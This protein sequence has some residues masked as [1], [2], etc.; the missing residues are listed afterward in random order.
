MGTPPW[1][2]LLRCPRCAG[3]CHDAPPVC[4]DCGFAYPSHGGIAV[5]H[6][7]PHALTDEWAFRVHDFVASNEKLRLRAIADAATGDRLASTRTRLLALADGLARHRNLLTAILLDAGIDAAERRGPPPEGVLGEASIT[8]YIHQIHRDWG[9]DDDGS[10]ENRAAAVAVAAVLGPSPALGRMLVLGAGACRLAA[11]VHAMGGATLT[12]A[13]DVNPLP[14]LVARRVLAGERVA[15]MELPVAPQRSDA[16][17]IER[18]LHGEHRLGSSFV[19]VFADAFALPFAPGSFDT[20]LTP[21]FID[22]VPHDIADLVPVVRGMLVDGGR[23]I[24]HGPLIYNPVHTQL[25]ARYCSDELLDLVTSAGFAVEAQRHDRLA[26][27]QSPAC[28]RGRAEMVFSF[29][30]RRVAR[31]QPQPGPQAPA[32]DQDDHLPV[33]AWDGLQ[34]YAAPHPLFAAVARLVDGQRSIADIAALM[35]RDYGLPPAAASGGVR[36]A[37][38]EIMRATADA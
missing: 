14:M 37:L 4:D 16:V 38:R 9:W 20:V 25:P 22:Q 1:V 8:S 30:A 17:V 27:M 24:N 3:R 31:P 28:T 32:W 11:D 35:I 23:W 34:R 7:R 26:Y 13:V 2:E 10:D 12:V 15:L 33:P 36:A 29:A 21:W 18:S 5:V 6:E 19:H